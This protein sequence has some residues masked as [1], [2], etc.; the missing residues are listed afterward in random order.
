MYLLNAREKGPSSVSRPEKFYIELLEQSSISSDHEQNFVVLVAFADYA[1]TAPLHK[2]AEATYISVV[3]E[4][5]KISLSE[6]TACFVADKLDSYR[7]KFYTSFL[8]VSTKEI[9]APQEARGAVIQ[10]FL[11]S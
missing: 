9:T 3:G 1:A 2:K 5:N 11:I 4:A 8:N 7:D 10:P 6:K